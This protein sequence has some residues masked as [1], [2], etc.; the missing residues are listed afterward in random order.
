VLCRWIK[1]LVYYQ[2]QRILAEMEQRK[3]STVYVAAQMSA[4]L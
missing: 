4:D 3:K 1:K 2:K